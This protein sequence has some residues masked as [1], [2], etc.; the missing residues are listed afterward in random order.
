MQKVDTVFIKNEIKEHL[1]GEY[2]DAKENHAND[3]ADNRSRIS[4]P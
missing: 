2:D 1:S 4:H 3:P